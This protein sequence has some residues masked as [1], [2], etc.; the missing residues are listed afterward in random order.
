MEK[1]NLIGTCSALLIL[2]LASLIFIFRLCGQARV[3][4]WLGIAFMVI[5]LPLVYLLVAA[6]RF[7]R[8]AIYYIQIVIMLVFIIA[9][10]LLDYVFRIE[11]RHTQW[12]A[13][14]YT[15][16]FFAGTGGMIGVAALSGKPYA[17]LSVCLFFIMAILAFYQR[18]KTG[19]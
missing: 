1:A 18:Q 9:E 5:A 17:I 6:N 16:L 13:I 3:E 2:L 11:F 7:D 12:M 19:M 4:Y 8:P 14:T 15:M 10:L